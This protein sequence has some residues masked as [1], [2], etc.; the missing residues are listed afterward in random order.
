MLHKAKGSIKAVCV[1]DARVDRRESSNYPSG[2]REF[3]PARV[4]PA[5][6]DSRE[7]SNYPLVAESSHLPESIERSE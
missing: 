7:S 1:P 2:S 3:T 5:R 4:D 6:V